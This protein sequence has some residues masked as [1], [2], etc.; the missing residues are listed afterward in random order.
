MQH[1]DTGIGTAYNKRYRNRVGAD[2]NRTNRN[3]NRKAVHYRLVM[4][5]HRYEI[6]PGYTA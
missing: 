1:R 3:R 2:T 5:Q 4:T 6:A